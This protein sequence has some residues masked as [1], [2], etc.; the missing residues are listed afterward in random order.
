[1]DDGIVI[2]RRKNLHTKNKNLTANIIIMTFRG[3]AD[4]VERNL[5]R[6]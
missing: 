4:I 5:F 1:M 2:M 3:C 6:P